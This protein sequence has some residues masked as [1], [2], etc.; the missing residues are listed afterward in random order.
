MADLALEGQKNWE[1]VA[2]KDQQQKLLQVVLVSPQVFS[3]PVVMFAKYRIHSYVFY[4]EKLLSI[5]EDVLDAGC[6]VSRRF[7]GIV[8]VL[9]EHVQ[10][11]V[12]GCTSSR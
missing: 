6:C 2:Q 4:Y 5:L 7:Q 9:Q 10:L 12:L 1:D 11:L 8:V 3:H